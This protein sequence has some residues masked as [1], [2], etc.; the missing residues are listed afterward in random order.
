MRRLSSETCAAIDAYWA[1]FFGCLPEALH[2]AESHVVSH[3]GLGD[4]AG[5]YAMTF[6]SA[7]PIVSVPPVYLDLA[8]SSAAGWSADTVDS[9]A[10]LRAL[11]GARAGDAIGPAIVSYLDTAPNHL[12]PFHSGV[13]ALLPSEPAH[14]TAVERLR[15][16][17]GPMEWA[18]GGC[19][20]EETP[21]VGVFHDDSLVALA[22]YE[23]WGERLAHIAVVTH[24][25]FRGRGSGRTAVA[26]LI[27]HLGGQHLIPQ[28]RT[29]A[30]NAASLRI[31]ASL[32]F[33]PY[34]RSMAVRFQGQD[35]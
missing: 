35:T 12:P 11:L 30:T 19:A 7:A 10:D 24:P 22:S 20:L 23:V 2:R 28:H 18:H 5:V 8:R 15:G 25:A 33:V 13:R 1:P 6:E 21:A 34:A 16:A 9:P 4:Y 14:R 26:G 27:A 29:L 31:A 32:G 17:C 3:A